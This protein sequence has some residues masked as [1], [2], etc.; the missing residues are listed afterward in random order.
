MKLRS[1]LK[2][3]TIHKVTKLSTNAML[4]PDKIIIITFDYTTAGFGLASENVTTLLPNIDSVQL[5]TIIRYHLNLTKHNVKI[6]KDDSKSYKGYL[7]SL[8]FTT[9]REEYKDAKCVMIRQIGETTI[10]F[11]TK[12]G[13]VSGAARGFQENQKENVVIGSDLSHEDFGLAVKQA[14]NKCS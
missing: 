13:G 4:Y 8:G 7:K 3:L 5:S 10:L 6:P 11:S 2:S 1:W 9:R 12:N 14:W